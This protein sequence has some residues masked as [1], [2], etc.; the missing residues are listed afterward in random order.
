MNWSNE[1]HAGERSTTSPAAA[2]DGGLLHGPLQRLHA[3]ERG[4]PAAPSAAGEVVGSLADQVRTVAVLEGGGQRVVRLR[5]PAA[6][7]DHVLAAAR[8]RR[9]RAKRCSRVRRLGVVDV[10]DTVDRR[11]LLDAVLD[12]GEGPEGLGDRRIGD[13]DRA[14]CGGRGRGVL[15]VVGAGDPRLG[16]QLVVGGELHA[17]RVA[18]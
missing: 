7:E 13:P 3:I 11:D 10:E 16:R 14:C 17:P 6:A 1:A 15:P 12:P 5:L 9:E 2:P 18:G 8:E 4:A